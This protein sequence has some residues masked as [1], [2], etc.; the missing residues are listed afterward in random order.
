MS[1][2]SNM[3]SDDCITNTQWMPEF[4][5]Y[6]IWDNDI[7]KAEMIKQLYPD[8][9]VLLFNSTTK[10]YTP[11]TITFTIRDP[12]MVNGRFVNEPVIKEG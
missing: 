1:L 6:V 7:S 2:L 10:Q 8:V 3:L 5:A 12:T 4:D 11:Y 9:H